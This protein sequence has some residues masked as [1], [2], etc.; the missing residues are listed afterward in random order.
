MN[1]SKNHISKT[2]RQKCY[3]RIFSA[4]DDDDTLATLFASHL[5]MGVTAALLENSYHSNH[6]LTTLTGSTFQIEAPDYFLNRVPNPERG[7]ANAN[8]SPNTSR[9]AFLDACCTPSGFPSAS[10]R[11]LCGVQSN[12]IVRICSH[13]RCGLMVNSPRVHCCCTRLASPA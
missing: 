2:L 6:G 5:H 1:A 11:E 10:A 4:D 3:N 8:H 13:C 12:Q 9:W 7:L